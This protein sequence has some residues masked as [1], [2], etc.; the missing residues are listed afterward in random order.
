[1]TTFPRR[2]GS[3]LRFLLPRRASQ[4]DLHLGEG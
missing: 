1:M 2:I 4:G 3:P